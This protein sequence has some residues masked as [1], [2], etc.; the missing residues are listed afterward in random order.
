M[1][2]CSAQCTR[3]SGFKYVRNK[4]ALEELF[5]HLVNEDHTETERER[6]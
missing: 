4:T 3:Y 6:E 5:V 1:G 2:F